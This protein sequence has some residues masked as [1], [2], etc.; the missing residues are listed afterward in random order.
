MLKSDLADLVM[1]A[2]DLETTNDGMAPASSV[3]DYRI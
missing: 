3:D 1:A 2:Y